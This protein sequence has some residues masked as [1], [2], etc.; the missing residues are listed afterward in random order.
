[1]DHA[2]GL[3]QE[4]LEPLKIE[5]IDCLETSVRNFTIR[6]SYLLRG[7]SQKSHIRTYLL[8]YLLTPYST[9]LEKL[10]GLQ[11]VKKFLEFYGTR[12][13]ITA[14]TIARHLSLFRASQIQFITP[15]STS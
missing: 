3:I 10:T 14:V 6:R 4:F 11:L 2:D 9:V 8:T 13:F 12:I 7:G 1:M 5:A 15:H